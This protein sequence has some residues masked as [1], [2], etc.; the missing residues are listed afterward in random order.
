M[1]VGPTIPG[2]DIERHAEYEAAADLAH[3]RCLI[4]HT[5]APEVASDVGSVEVRRNPALG[6][7]EGPLA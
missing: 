2:G 7:G 4:G 3:D 6:A 5:L 1:M